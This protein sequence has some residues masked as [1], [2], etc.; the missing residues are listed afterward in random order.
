MNINHSRRVSRYIFDVQNFKCSSAAPPGRG[1]R[2]RM[3][4]LRLPLP[5]LQELDRGALT[6]LVL[7]G[8]ATV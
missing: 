5:A 3:S 2:L 1:P 8:G 4:V 6:G 7:E